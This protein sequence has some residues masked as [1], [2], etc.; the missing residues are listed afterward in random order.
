MKTVR[1]LFTSETNSTTTRQSRDGARCRRRKAGAR[2]RGAGRSAGGRHRQLQPL[3]R[4]GDTTRS[5]C[6]PLSEARHAP[7]A[8]QA[9]RRVRDAPVCSLPEIAGCCRCTH[10]S[11]CSGAGRAAVL[12]LPRPEKFRAEG[13]PADARG[14]GLGPSSLRP[15]AGWS[16]PAPAGCP[17]CCAAAPP[18]GPPGWSPRRGT[19]PG[20]GRPS[21]ARR[22]TR[23]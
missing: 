16:R 20:P 11:C 19:R 22:P 18:S 10:C 9:S 14:L 6:P 17:S 13:D 12:V 2:P 5:L 7:T 15:S 3:H 8:G 23:R 21:S 1:N 4:T